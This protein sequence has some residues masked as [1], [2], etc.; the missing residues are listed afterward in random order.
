MSALTLENVT[1]R[2][3]ER[4]LFSGLSADLPERGL[5]LLLGESGTG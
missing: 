5:Y 2:F 3:G 4:T 1:K